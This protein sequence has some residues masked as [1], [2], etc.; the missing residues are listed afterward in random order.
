M[1]A[2]GSA[3]EVSRRGWS[4][5]R[6]GALVAAVL[7]G[8]AAV[9]AL[10]VVV[11]LWQRGKDEE[12]PEFASLV[13]DPDPS[14]TGGIAVL[15][16]KTEPCVMVRSAS[17]EW[18]NEDLEWC[19]PG[20]TLRWTDD[21]HLEHLAYSNDTVKGRPQ[22]SGQRA[23]GAP[24]SGQLIDVA[25]GTVTP[26]DPAEMPATPPASLDP[27]RGPDGQRAVATSDDGHV[28]VAIEGPEGSRTVM[29]ADGGSLYTVA[30]QGWAPDG[31]WL[32]L[33]DSGARY[34]LVTLGD[35]PQTRILDDNAVGEPGA[36]AIT[37]LEPWA[38]GG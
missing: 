28:E 35:D 26:V 4:A 32:L 27:T 17:G 30:V 25:T 34:L 10:V 13:E 37:S 8:L 5:G 15:D 7:V 21:G 12:V 23:G 36:V 38:E 1:D 29:T 18:R 6:V 16:G 2:E 3:A 33:S 11:G 20:R 9:L 22:E 14:L 19:A 24:V 31:S